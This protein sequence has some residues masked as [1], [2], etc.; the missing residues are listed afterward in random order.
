[1]KESSLLPLYQKPPEVEKLDEGGSGALPMELR[2]GSAD[3]RDR[4]RSLD[5]LVMRKQD[6]G[7]GGS[8]GL[9]PVGLGW[10]VQDPGQA[11]VPG[12]DAI[13]S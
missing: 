4:T 3:C 7:Q 6:G 2:S 1:M 9:V 11:I 10:V 12:R 5:T 8:F 13:A